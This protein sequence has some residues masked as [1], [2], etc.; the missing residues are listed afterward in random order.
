LLRGRLAR[1][2]TL[3]A[4]HVRTHFRNGLTAEH[5]WAAPQET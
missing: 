4:Q 1:S 3:I 5:R 2:S